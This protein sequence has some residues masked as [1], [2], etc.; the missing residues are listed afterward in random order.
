MTFSNFLLAMFLLTVSST[1]FRKET[2]MNTVQPT[3]N[4]VCE[5]NTV[6]ILVF[7]FSSGMK[8]L[9][10]DPVFFNWE[11]VINTLSIKAL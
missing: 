3:Y 9:P 2:N 6:W 11:N 10:I 7:R 4:E 8:H 5:I 1:S